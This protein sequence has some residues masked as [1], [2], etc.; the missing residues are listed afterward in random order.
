ML[1]LKDFT[2]KQK[3]KFLLFLGIGI[4]AISK[5][6]A[7]Q[8]EGSNRSPM[9]QTVQQNL[10]RIQGRVFDSQGEPI[11]GATVREK[12]TSNGVVT[13]ME[14]KFTLRVS[15]TGKLQI[16]YVGY[17]TQELSIGSQRTFQITLKEDTELLDEVVVVGYGAVRKSDLTGAVASVSTKDLLKSGKTDAVG[18]MQGVLPGVQ[19]QRANNKPGGEYNIL[20]RGLNTI[21]GSTA[22]L[23]VVDGVPGASLSNLNPD[24]IEKID[25]LK[26]AS[27]TAIYGSRATNGVVM[28][29]TKRGQAGKVK[30]DY[31]GYAGFRKYTNMPDM[32]SGEEYVQL[33][34][35]AA[36]AGNNNEYKDDSEI[37][38]PSE[39]KAIKDG[40]YFDWVDA[41]S[42]PAFMTNHT[43]SATGGNEMASYALSA[44][45]YYEDGMLNPQEYSRYNLRAV[46]DVH[47]NKYI[48]FGINM[49]GTH[50]VRDT[51][52]SDLLQDAFRLR[53]TYHPVDLVTGEEM[54]SYSNGQYN[55]I[56]TQKNELNKTKKYNLLSNIYLNIKPI[57]NLSLKTTFSPNINLEE[58]GQYRGK[59]TKANKGQNKATSNYAKNSY[60]D[61][62]WDNQVTYNF[63][64]N[65]HRLDV[66]GVFSMQQTQDETLKG[67]GN[68]LSYNSLWYNLAGGADSNSSSS[69]FTKTN[70][71]SYLARANYVYKNKYFV[72]ASIRF[73]GSSKLAEGNKWGAFSSAALAWRISEENFM[74][75]LSWL[76][77][78]KLRLSFGQTGNDNV[79]AYQ[80]Q[81]TINGAKY[82][83]F[84]TND[85]IG[86]V[87]NNLRNLELGWE[88]TTEYNIGL[89]FGFLDNRIS[90]SIEYYNRLT[91]DLIMNKTLPV[92]LGYSSVKANV[93]SVRNKGFEA[94]INSENIRTKDF[95]W[96]TSLNFAYNK[97]SIVDLQYKED[98]TSR[99]PSF[100]GMSGDYSNLWIIG[101]PI[102]INYNL[103]TIGV[104]QLN[105]AEEAAK[106]GCRPGQYKVLDLNEDGII[107]DKDRV[108]DGKR[109]PDW[110]GGMTNS[111][112]YKDFD[113]S[114]QLAFQTG[115]KARNQFYVSYALENNNQNFNNL[116]K[117]YW[118]PENPTN[119]S[120]QPSNMGTYRDK[121][122]PWGNTKSAMTHTMFSSN[123]LKMSYITLG[124]TFRQTLLKKINI[125]SLRLYAT[126]Q[127]PFIWCA[128]D[129][130]DPEQLSVSINT[131]DVMTRNVIFGL[132][133]S[134]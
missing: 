122:G 100:A 14:G 49:Y 16:S 31:S 70:L 64:K 108:I 1:N 66:T 127:N 89:D 88:R 93:G 50:S 47:P 3:E 44:G 67:I 37:F 105:E 68:G 38:T 33:A 59:Y 26:D 74:K 91:D 23:I 15:T 56:T 24:D 52:N 43:I 110:T 25:I 107:D 95:S 12:D 11:I 109:T 104:W 4:L 79:S 123:F 9:V 41:V 85:V 2:M 78:L 121:A 7:A 55:A 134:F 80:T 92:T 17:S 102:D 111:F 40:N 106:Y 39:L 86:Y 54:W 90:G 28:V 61:W 34:R 81:G 103:V 99:G 118:T 82:Y 6:Y 124:Y 51:G 62:V 53:P 129:V 130:V 8:S 13:D 30:I 119:E 29:T 58:I 128:D 77:N 132:N 69:G 45:Y 117:D 57:K 71:M 94:I 5:A 116:R 19:I 18:A 120:A 84:G 131:S 32:M 35:E 76:S 73:D 21:N 101:Q 87:P 97:N 126:V 36:R 46:V 114:F 48:D 75:N 83:S 63:Q 133:L 20:I 96:T 60:V 113:L 10:V 125:S 42:S 115:A 65:E 27:S 98:L 22:P 112:T 72:T